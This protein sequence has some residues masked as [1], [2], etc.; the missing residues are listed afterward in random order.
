MQTKK[1]LPDECFWKY[2]PNKPRTRRFAA[3]RAAQQKLLILKSFA[4]ASLGFKAPA[5]LLKSQSANLLQYTMT[6]THSR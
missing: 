5:I 1:R 2:L 3:D 6:Y 4:A